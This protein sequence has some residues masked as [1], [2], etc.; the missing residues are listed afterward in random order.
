ME[1]DLGKSKRDQSMGKK[2]RS[3]ERKLRDYKHFLRTRVQL[4]APMR[5]LITSGT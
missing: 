4:P 1:T 2:E 3:L 5:E